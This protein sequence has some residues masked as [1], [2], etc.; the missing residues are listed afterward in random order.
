[1]DEER[2]LFQYPSNEA[3]CQ[4]GEDWLKKGCSSLS[5][6]NPASPEG[7]AGSLPEVKVG[8]A[9]A[10]RTRRAGRPMTL[11]RAG[12]LRREGAFSSV[13]FVGTAG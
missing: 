1:M 12:R 3:S 13:V 9:Q 10:S 7:E 6:G 4:R 11:A 5:S 8:Y 2:E